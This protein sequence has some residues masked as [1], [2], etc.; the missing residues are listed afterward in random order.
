MQRERAKKSFAEEQGGRQ[1]GRQRRKTRRKNNLSASHM[2]PM[3]PTSRSCMRSCSRSQHSQRPCND[4][5]KLAS[6][7]CSCFLHFTHACHLY[8][9]Q[10]PRFARSLGRSLGDRRVHGHHFI[11]AGLPSTMMRRHAAWFSGA[12]TEAMRENMEGLPMIQEQREA[13]LI[14]NHWSW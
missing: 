4:K 8:F 10:C 7:T 12:M 2:L 1:G 3:F 13:R 11:G 5:C 6:C 14:S 9:R